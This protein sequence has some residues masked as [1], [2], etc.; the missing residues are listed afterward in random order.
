MTELPI[1]TK[2]N[3]ESR[4]SNIFYEC[5]LPCNR[6]KS[7]VKRDH[8][9]QEERTTIKE[10]EDLNEIA[11]GSIARAKRDGDKG[12]PYRVPRSSAKYSER[13]SFV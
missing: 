12:Q 6:I 3:E 5:V 8:Q 7:L 10:V 13:I 9:P 1:Y 4:P 2:Q 11:S